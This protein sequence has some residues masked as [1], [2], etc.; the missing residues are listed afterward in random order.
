LQCVA[1]HSAALTSTDTKDVLVPGIKTCQTCHNGA[2][3][4]YGHAENRCFECHQY[5][6]WMDRGSFK[7]TYSLPQLLGTAQPPAPP[8]AK[9]W[10]SVYAQLF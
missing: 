1:C 2:P 7:G 4:T 8:Q 10:L 5:H 9:S 6:N 3:T